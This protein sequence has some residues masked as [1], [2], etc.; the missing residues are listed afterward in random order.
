MTMKKLC[1][2]PELKEVLFKYG[3]PLKQQPP[4]VVVGEFKSKSGP[5]YGVIGAANNQFHAYII[6]REIEK[7]GKAKVFRSEYHPKG[8]DFCVADYKRRVEALLKEHKGTKEKPKSFDLE[9]IK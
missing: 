8:M 6:R 5:I 1:S 2:I 9:I 7:N 3:M 4:Y